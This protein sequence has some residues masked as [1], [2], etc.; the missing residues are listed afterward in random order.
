MR[1]SRRLV[2]VKIGNIELL[3][4]HSEAK[5]MRARAWNDV[6]SRINLV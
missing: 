2:I 6:D 1:A 5:C 3:N 4:E